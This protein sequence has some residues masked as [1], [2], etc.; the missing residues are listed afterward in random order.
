M[1]KKINPKAKALIELVYAING[2]DVVDRLFHFGDCF[3]SQCLLHK[4]ITFWQNV[5]NSWLEVM[6][7]L[8]LS[9]FIKKQFLNI[10]VWY[11]SNITVNSHYIMVSE[12]N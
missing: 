5:L 11:N 3:I 8:K 6:K 9:R 1:D 4:N 10:P 2:N 12:R 7:G